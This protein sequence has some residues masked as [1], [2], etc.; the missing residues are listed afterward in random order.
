MQIVVREL[1]RIFYCRGVS[2]VE[3]LV[4]TMSIGQ[5]KEERNLDPISKSIRGLDQSSAPVDR[6]FIF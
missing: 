1:A 6:F 3:D 4:S 2:F 5:C